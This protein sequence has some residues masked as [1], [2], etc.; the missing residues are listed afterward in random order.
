MI[1][2]TLK[3]YLRTDRSNS[4]GKHQ[5]YL[6]F[7]KQRKPRKIG[8][9]LWINKDHWKGEYPTF[10]SDVDSKIVN[11]NDYNLYLSNKMRHARK[12]VM[13]AQS[14][15]TSISFEKFKEV[16]TGNKK[17][18]DF[19]SLH[20][21]IKESKIRKGIAK[22]TLKNYTKEY[23]RL[24]R[25]SEKI[26]VTMIDQNM[27]DRVQSFFREIGNGNTTIRRT[28]GHIKLVTDLAKQKKLIEDDPFFNYDLPKRKPKKREYLEQVEL[29]KLEKLYWSN[30]LINSHQN[31]LKQFLAAC[32]LGIDFGCM[33]S[34]KYSDIKRDSGVYYIDRQRSKNGIP[35]IVPISKKAFV[36]MELGKLISNDKGLIFR[37]ISN[38][39]TNEYLQEMILSQ[40]ITRK[41]SFHCARHTFGTLT[42]NKGVALEAVRK[43]MGH[44][45]I[46]QT[47]YYSRINSDLVL[48][49]LN[50]MNS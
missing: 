16:F 18:I 8:M 9:G 37:S 15:N 11:S 13:D 27:L 20:D 49:S 42:T 29:D 30:T 2:I 22:E 26:D 6:R 19:F 35:Y 3:Y 38:Q 17:A 21:E 50:K 40:G 10:I 43:M 1:A 4:E 33:C 24:K 28:L 47:E 41:I 45:S 7:T 32:Y 5:I 12:I 46:K 14:D 39:K 25:F 48:N 31:V 34:L 23:R 36:L 44:S